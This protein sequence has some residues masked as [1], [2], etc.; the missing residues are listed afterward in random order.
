M[1]TLKTLLIILALGCAGIA[2]QAMQ[3]D[4]DSETDTDRGYYAWEDDNL[5]DNQPP[6]NMAYAIGSGDSSTDTDRGY[7]SDND[8]DNVPNSLLGHVRN[9][10]GRLF[11]R[12]QRQQQDD[13]DLENMEFDVDDE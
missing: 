10:L 5:Y 8:L 12:P 13:D 1:K 7:D 2:A 11:G 3:S 6:A 9:L 4:S